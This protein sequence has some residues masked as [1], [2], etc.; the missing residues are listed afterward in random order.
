MSGDRLLTVA[1]AAEEFFVP[2]KTVRRWLD[3]ELL[4]WHRPGLLL[5]TDVAAV[6][7]RTRRLRR[8][9]HLLALTSTFGASFAPRTSVSK[10]G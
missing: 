3:R 2:E 1:E 7:A 8:T 5:D 4:N 9:R 10:P 6:E